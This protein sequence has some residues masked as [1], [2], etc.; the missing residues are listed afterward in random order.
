MARTFAIEG[1][2][3][4]FA[5]NEKSHRILMI[6]NLYI[7]KALQANTAKDMKLEKG[8]EMFGDGDGKLNQ[9]ESTV[10]LYQ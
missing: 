7:N 2:F 3:I 8:E 10:R 1:S 5:T 9:R 6:L 4:G